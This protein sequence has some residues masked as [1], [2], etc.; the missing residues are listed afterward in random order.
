MILVMIVDD[1]RP[2]RMG[3]A[4]MVAKD[5]TLHVVAQAANGQDALDQ[6]ATAAENQQPLPDVIL[7][8][9][10][11]PVMDGLDATSRIKSSILK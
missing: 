3:L 11:M 5:P 9:V 6:L 8:D 7:M 1:Q 4:L 10:R 2:T